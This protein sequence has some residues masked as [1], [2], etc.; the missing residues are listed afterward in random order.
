MKPK[1]INLK[2]RKKQ[3]KYVIYIY[4]LKILNNLNLRI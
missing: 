3:L 1:R 2:T 4:I